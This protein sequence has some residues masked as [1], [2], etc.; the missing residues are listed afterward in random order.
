[1][2]GGTAY[3]VVAAAGAG[4]ENFISVIGAVA[5]NLGIG[6]IALIVRHDVERKAGIRNAIVDNSLLLSGKGSLLALAS[7]T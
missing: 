6:L 7:I 1:L 3:R 2:R 5:D 4:I